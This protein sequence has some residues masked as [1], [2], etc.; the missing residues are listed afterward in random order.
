MAELAHIYI[1]VINKCNAVLSHC[2]EYGQSN[3]NLKFYKI[4]LSPIFSQITSKGK[5]TNYKWSICWCWATEHCNGFIPGRRQS[6]TL[7]ISGI[8][9]KFNIGIYCGAKDNFF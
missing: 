3:K 6:V 8:N 9:E 2:T 7:D 5:V 1:A 4:D